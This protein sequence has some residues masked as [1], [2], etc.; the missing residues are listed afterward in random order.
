M[1]VHLSAKRPFAV[2]LVLWGV[3]L[4]GV[5]NLGRAITLY[6]QLDVL[7]NLNIHV[8]PR[9][10]LV[11][12]SFWVILFFWLAWELRKRKLFCQRAIPAALFFFALSDLILYA[13]V[14]TAVKNPWWLPGLFFTIII[15]FSLW[16]LNNLRAKHYFSQKQFTR[17]DQ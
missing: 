12:A 9:M 10:R 5:W 13:F 15:L 16:A 1:S 11:I 7:L 17:P 14:P 4:F 8:D 2:T 6:Q 3:I